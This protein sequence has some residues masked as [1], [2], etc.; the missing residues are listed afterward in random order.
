MLLLLACTAASAALAQPGYYDPD[1]FGPEESWQ[2]APPPGEAYGPV[3]AAY[4][5]EIAYAPD[6]A[7]NGPVGRRVSLG[8]F[9]A[10]LNPYGSW[11][12]VAGVGRAWRPFPHVVGAGF[13]PYATNGRWVYTPRGWSFRSA[14]PF[15]WA[16]FHYG[17]WMHSPR[18]GWIWAPGYTWAPAWVSWRRHGSYVA[19]APIAPTGF[20]VRFGFGNVGWN[21]VTVQ[22]FRRPHVV[23]YVKTPGP[24]HG[25]DWRRDDRHDRYDRGPRNDHRGQGRRGAYLAPAAPRP[26]AVPSRGPVVQ[27]RRL[28]PP[29]P[30]R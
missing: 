8:R 3:P 16:T 26:V 17:R 25:R 2:A 7:W 28:P 27:A 4:P 18:F 13:V 10:S 15:G 6:P 20:E 21:V 11:V 19:W 22:D 29:P 23:R 24:R 14:Y 9:E 1:G 12:Y 30:G 5:D